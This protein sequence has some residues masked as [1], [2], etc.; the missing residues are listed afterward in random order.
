MF[1]DDA[2]S[3]VEPEASLESILEESLHLAG[4][5]EGHSWIT[6]RKSTSDYF[7]SI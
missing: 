3:Y 1:L 7:L 2:S 4:R 5:I 6:I